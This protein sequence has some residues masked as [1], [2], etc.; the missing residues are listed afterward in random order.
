MKKKPKARIAIVDDHAIVRQG[1]TQLLNSTG[2]FT[3][4][5]EAASPAEA[6][7][8]IGA[9]NPDCAIVDLCLGKA[10]G[11]DLIEAIIGRWP[12]LPILVLSMY[13]ETVYAE[14]SLRAGARGYVMKRE[15]SETLME[16][17]REVLAGEIYVAR[18]MRSRILQHLVAARAKGADS[19]FETLTN[20]ELEVFRLLGEGQATSEIAGRLSLSVKTIETY[21]ARIKEKLDVPN[22][23]ELTRRAILWVE[24]SRG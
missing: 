15:V 22:A 16:A 13:D 3:V 14:R 8:A 12:N 1:L 10:S 9:S 24:K 6:M 18:S 11:L 19:P 23:R 20:R 21:C 5:A 2:R 17:L 7:L 4:C